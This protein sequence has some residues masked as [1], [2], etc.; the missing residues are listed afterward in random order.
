MNRLPVETQVRLPEPPV[1]SPTPNT[2]ILCPSW[3]IP[4]VGLEQWLAMQWVYQQAFA[5]AQ[6][7]VKP[8]IL[9]RDLLGCWN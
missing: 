8:S 2:F 7:V 4:G 3:L 6:A 1:S 5:E 9:E